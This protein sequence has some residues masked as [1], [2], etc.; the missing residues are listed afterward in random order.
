MAYRFKREFPKQFPVFLLFMLLLAGSIFAQTT[1][2]ITGTVTSAED[3]EPLAG[4]NVIVVGTYL[5]A[6]ADADG[7]FTIVNVPPGL[8]EVQVTMMGYQKMTQ[9]NVKVS[10]DQITN[11]T[12]G[13]GA[14]V[15]EGEGVVVTAERDILHKEVSN[16]QLVVS[17]EEM[18]EAAGIRTINNYLEK[19]AGVTG[20][21]HLEIRGG[22]ADQTGT[23][24]NG[25]TLVNTRVGEAEAGIPISAVEEV[26]LVTG[27][28]SAEYGNFR[29]GL[30]NIVTKSGDKDAYHGTVNY[31]RNNP[32]MKRFGKSLYDPTNVFLRP[33]FD[34]NVAFI[35]T[36]AAWPQEEYPVENEE[37]IL[38]AGWDRMALSYN[39]SAPADK[40]ITP[41]DM[42]LWAAWM[43]MVEPD[44]E[45]LK[46]YCNENGIDYT[47]TEEQMKAIREH[48]HEDEGSHS[49]YNIDVGFGGPL[50]FISKALGDATFYLSHQSV[51]T[52]YIQP[53]TRN[54]NLN[55]TTM[56]TIQSNIDKTL[57]LKINSIYRKVDG[58]LPV[59]PTSGSIP[60]LGDDNDADSGGGGFMYENNIAK[61]FDQ[62][63][64]YYWH[65]T[66]WL[67]K[68]QTISM[69]G[70]S[71]NK[72]IN[73][74]TFWDLALSYTWQKDYC[75]NNETR[76]HAA[77]VNFGPVWLDEMPYGR[78]FTADTVYNP[79][80]LSDYYAH[81]IFEDVGGDYV[82]ATGRRFSSKTGQYHDNSVTQQIRAKFDLSSQVTK[83]HFIKT[84]IDFNYTDLNNNLWV[85]WTGYDTDY[86][87][88][89]HRKPWQSGLYVQ[90]QITYAGIVA[91]IGLRADYYNS[92]GDVWPT[93]DRYITEAFVEGAEGAHP[94]MDAYRYQFMSQGI[95]LVWDRW[96]AI[97]QAYRDSTGRAF[98]EKTANH[99]ALSP[100]IGI[101]FP[102]TERSKF[103]F[104]YGHFRSTVPYSEMFM[105]NFR[106]S[107][108]QGLNYIGNPDL[109]PPRTI[110]YELGG[111]YNLL[112][113]YLINVSGFY[114]DVTGE[115][116]RID[117]D[118]QD[119]S[120]GY[121][122]R[123][124][125][126][127]EDIQGLE[128][129]V[130]KPV[131]EFITGWV[132]FRY[133][134]S[135]DGSVG[136]RYWYEDPEQNQD[137]LQI[138]Y[139]AEED[140]PAPRPK[141]AAN[142]TFHVPGDLKMG[143][144]ANTILG[145]WLI[146]GI[147]EWEQGE[148][149]THNPEQLRNV[150]NN[151]RWPDY[152]MVDLK[153]SKSFTIQGIRA[154]FYVD[155]QNLLNLK[156]NWMH[157]EWCFRSDIDRDDY[158]N[159]LHLPMYNDPEYEGQ[160]SPS[161]TPYVGGN[162]KVG[163]LKSDDK[164]YINNPNND[165]LWLYGYPR[166]IWVGLNISF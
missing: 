9:T 152:Y 90:D 128:V 138:Y 140:R 36:R 46:S 75:P 107:K 57:T 109:A 67:P 40:Q 38:F 31:S 34:P 131:G 45:A 106:Y 32:H 151:L 74:K 83:H 100:R 114:K 112:D 25:L 160:T 147:F 4:A 17:N 96:H 76:D 35:G 81:N 69:T 1:G 3:G 33:L 101:S 136:R 60:S 137:P 118:G 42:Y 26:S 65:P 129:D 161:G 130:R 104:N 18:V 126:R 68:E 117:F 124:N 121:A 95:N 165:D 62:G 51:N 159:S 143:S 146:S 20:A 98:L 6:A 43:Y 28:Y 71:L 134:L 84:G 53:V 88:R 30:I 133:F 77:L 91:R 108:G 116:T 122:S 115:Q 82:A 157:N 49:D 110:S 105:Y 166:D 162:D 15:V 80:D 154:N 66:F 150:S 54:A 37:Y 119:I 10:V 22:S 58:T 86:D 48:A 72:V 135:K 12:F 47:V 85:Y 50:P 41:L 70:L 97:D 145:D 148:A 79:N 94:A 7:Y 52:N 156:V 63:N 141:V 8:Y 158:L 59:M 132:N 39:R 16:S 23:I 149:F 2:K 56:L 21:N 127:Y 120:D 113:E 11:L 103:Y 87:L 92:G 155:I 73:Q 142:L 163:D 19:Q 24:I 153:I 55:S 111:S 139:A 93:G 123:T 44:F 89:I 14:E 13:L 125:N 27:G 5:G 61:I 164:P 144:I 29:S 78:V 64:V 99:F 102:V